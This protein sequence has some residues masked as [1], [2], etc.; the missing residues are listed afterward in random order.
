MNGQIAVLAMR[1]RGQRPSD[2][3]VLVLDAE[4]TARGFMAAEDSIN[5]GGFPEIDISPTDVPSLLDLRCLRGVRVHVCGRNAQ[6]VRAVANH[7]REFEPTE[8]LAVADGAILRWKPK[9]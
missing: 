8:I 9:P 7:V 2:V 5:C 6:R 3:F 4:P 1:K